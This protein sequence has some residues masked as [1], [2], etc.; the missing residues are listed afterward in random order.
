MTNPSRLLLIERGQQFELA[1]N[2]AEAAGQYLAAAQ[3]CYLDDA[4]FE[5]ATLCLRAVQ[6]VRKMPVG[7]VERDRVLA[8]S[9]LLSLAAKERDWRLPLDGDKAD[10]PRSLAFEAGEAAARTCDSALIA[11]VRY[12]IGKM[13]IMF[14]SRFEAVATLSEALIDARVADDPLAELVILTALGGQTAGGNIE[15]GVV[16]LKQALAVYTSG[17]RGHEPGESFEVIDITRSYVHLLQALG[18][19]EFDRGHFDEAMVHLEASR[20]EIE[21]SEIKGELDRTLNYLGQVYTATGKFE[22]A[23]AALKQALAIHMEPDHRGSTHPWH[24]YNLGQLG[25]LYLEWNRLDDAY[26]MIEAAWDETN[27]AMT[28]ALSSLVANFLAEVLIHPESPHRDEGRAEQLLRSTITRE[29]ETGFYRS[30]VAANS[31]LGRLALSQNKA[32]EAYAASSEAVTELERRGS[33]PALR[34]EEVLL[35][36]ARI[37]K[38][39]QRDDEAKLYLAKAHDVL[40]QRA[41]TLQSDEDRTTFLERVPLSTAITSWAALADRAV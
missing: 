21:A 20:E 1:D 12:F 2:P 22:L 3:A 13:L 41:S 15:E 23:E 39:V 16:L 5:T 36:H 27:N 6:H 33:L 7:S 14:E 40:M 19:A 10:D 25:K 9:I 32:L 4:M 35:H 8:E 17:I 30:R 28:V 31:L 11:R 34:T 37:C 24:A 29:G 18:V 26:P 38:V